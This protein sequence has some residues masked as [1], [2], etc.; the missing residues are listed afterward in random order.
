M[1]VTWRLG[2]IRPSMSNH[3]MITLHSWPLTG[4]VLDIA[5][6][7]T[8][9]LM[10]LRLGAGLPLPLHVLEHERAQRGVRNQRQTE[11]KV[12]NQ[13]PET[14]RAFSALGFSAYS[15]LQSQ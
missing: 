8:Q 11:Q 13:P 6:D 4:Q 12:R 3:D 5:D 14:P 9:E 15:F 2:G 7:L 10:V 1:H